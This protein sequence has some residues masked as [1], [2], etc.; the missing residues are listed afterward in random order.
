MTHKK[1]VYKCTLSFLFIIN[2]YCGVLLLLTI[3]VHLNIALNLSV[4]WNKSAGCSALALQLF[5]FCNHAFLYNVFI[6]YFSPP[7]VY[8]NRTHLELR[9]FGQGVLNEKEA[10]GKSFKNERKRGSRKVVHLCLTFFLC[11]SILY[12][13]KL[14][15]FYVCKCYCEFVSK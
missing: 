11:F 12:Y 15:G 2:R 14:G 4:C 10:A 7:N 13:R 5:M 1:R 9:F 3:R 8:Q 6:S